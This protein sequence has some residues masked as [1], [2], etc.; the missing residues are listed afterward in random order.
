MLRAFFVAVLVLSV[1][2]GT[3]SAYSTTTRKPRT[4]TTPKLIGISANCTQNITFCSVQLSNKGNTTYTCANLTSCL[5]LNATADTLTYVCGN[6]TGCSLVDSST[7]NGCC[8]VDT[9]IGLVVGLGLVI[10]LIVFLSSVS[11]R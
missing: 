8:T 5:P 7:S 2:M 3:A 6:L 4:T 9:I 11:L 10:V 1:V